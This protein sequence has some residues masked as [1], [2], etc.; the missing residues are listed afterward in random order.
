[1]N[2]NNKNKPK[3]KYQ[4]QVITHLGNYKKEELKIDEPGIFRHKGRDLEYD[5]ILP[6]NLSYLNILEMYRD[7]FNSSKYSDIDYHRYFHHLNSSQALCI[8]LFYPL[9]VEGRLDLILELLNLP[10]GEITNSRLEYES[11]LEQT[12]NGKTNFDFYFEILQKPKIYFEIKYTEQKFGNAEKDQSHI[13]KFEKTYEPLLL[14]NPY[15]RDEYKTMEQFLENYQIMRNL[16]HISEDSI[17]V[18]LYPFANSKIHKQASRA[19][20]EIVT[21]EGRKQ[22]KILSLEETVQHIVGRL[23]PGLLKRH[24]D[25]FEMK[26]L[27][28]TLTN[29]FLHGH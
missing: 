23:K 10:G 24:F 28:K 5:H 17:V 8:N 20:D 25:E 13:D 26:Y 6:K 12:N 4:D 1:M 22:L 16:V 21:E 19:V 18:F 15:L 27:C 7:H 3:T 2:M 14:D 29:K 9:I 11:D